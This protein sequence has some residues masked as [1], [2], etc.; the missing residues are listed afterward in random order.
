MADVT[1]AKQPV[2]MAAR[3][4]VKAPVLTAVRVDVAEVVKVAVRGAMRT[5]VAALTVVH[6]AVA[7][8]QQLVKDLLKVRQRQMVT[9]LFQIHSVLQKHVTLQQNCLLMK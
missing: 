7:V 2:W 5:V 3:P 4:V 8:A 9:A 6:R 1:T